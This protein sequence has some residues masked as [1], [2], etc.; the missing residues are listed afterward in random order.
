MHRLDAIQA[1][2]F[3][4]PAEMVEQLLAEARANVIR[5]EPQGRLAAFLREWEARKLAVQAQI[6]ERAEQDVVAL[7]A[8][9]DRL[10]AASNRPD[11]ARLDQFEELNTVIAAMQ[12]RHEQASEAVRI[13]LNSL[14]NRA[15]EVERAVRGR[16]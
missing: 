6:D 5:G 12:K 14:A 10:D 7:T 16:Q 3:V 1:A 13:H 15:A 9:L 8:T 4:E 2:K 11:S